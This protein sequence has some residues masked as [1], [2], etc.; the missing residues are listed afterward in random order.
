[1]GDYYKQTDTWKISKDFVPADPASFDIKN[2]VLS[3]LR[4]NPF[5][6]NMIQDPWENKGVTAY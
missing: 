3:I 1:M 4:Y 5:D 6:G 2:H